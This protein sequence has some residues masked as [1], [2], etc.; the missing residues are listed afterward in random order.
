MNCQLK[1]YQLH[2]PAIKENIPFIIGIIQNQGM[3]KL[4]INIKPATMS[5]KPNNTKLISFDTKPPIEEEIP[6]NETII[7]R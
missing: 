6:F 5:I 3:L 2:K 7:P 4:N 1:D